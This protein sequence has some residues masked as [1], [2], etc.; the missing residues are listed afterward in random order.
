MKHAYF[1]A[2]TVLVRNGNVD[3]A[4]SLLN[5]VLGREGIFDQWRH[6]RYFEKP[7]QTRRRVNYMR[8]KSI[9]NEDMDRKIKFVMRKNRV[10]P[11][12]GCY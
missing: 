2:R 1:V 4:V 10:E 6:T 7:C 9:Y 8:C 11:F 12:V 5:R 3:E